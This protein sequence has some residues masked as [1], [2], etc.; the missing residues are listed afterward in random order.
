MIKVI[1]ATPKGEL[2]NKDVES[3][4]ISGD[5]GQLG[6][7]ANRI[8]L[9]TKITKGFVKIN[10]TNVIYVGIVN[11]V[12]DFKDNVATVIA[13]NAAIGNTAEEAHQVIEENLNLINK[14]NKQKNVDFV[15]AEKELI[16][17][18]KEMKA[19]HID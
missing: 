6:V 8:P 19:A 16:K 12:V 4:V 7:L 2:L 10:D 18:I 13:Q 5:T 1:V 3:I 17:N 9:L 11:G 15:E 14:A